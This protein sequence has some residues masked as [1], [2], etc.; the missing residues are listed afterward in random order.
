MSAPTVATAMRY[1]AAALISHQAVTR[2]LAEA[3]G[4]IAQAQQEGRDITEGEWQSALDR[5]ERAE[6]DALDALARARAREGGRA[7]LWPLALLAVAALLSAI[8][9]PA[10]AQA[11]GTVEITWEAPEERMDGTPLGAHEMSTFELGC[12]LD[13][14]EDELETLLVLDA[15]VREHEGHRADF[16]PHFGDWECAMLVELT[17]GL[18]SEWSDTR[19]TIAWPPSAPQP[20]PWS[21]TVL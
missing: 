8:A 4:V 6:R 2:A 17:D 21:L 16:L 15:D 14:T 11:P 20:P 5:A 18:R 7:T 12:R 9:Y 13:G 1:I 19:G 10:L 3:S